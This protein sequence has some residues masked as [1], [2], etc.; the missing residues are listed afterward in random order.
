MQVQVV[1]NTRAKVDDLPLCQTPLPI[2]T[3]TIRGVQGR[4][5]QKMQEVLYS[6]Y[7]RKTF[8]KSLDCP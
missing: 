2:S 1:K 5:Y 7:F 6:Q 3:F 4:K 8:G